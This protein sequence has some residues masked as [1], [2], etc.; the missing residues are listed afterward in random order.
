[1]PYLIKWLIKRRLKMMANNLE[2]VSQKG[3]SRGSFGGKTRK[4]ELQ[5][6]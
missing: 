4:F 6:C 3:N 2:I 1:M 5:N